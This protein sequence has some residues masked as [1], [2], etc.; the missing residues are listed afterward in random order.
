MSAKMSELSGLELRKAACEALS[1]KPDSEW[2]ATRDG[3]ATTAI[4]MSVRSS[5]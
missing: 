1:I 5:Y 3:G 2:V 4:W